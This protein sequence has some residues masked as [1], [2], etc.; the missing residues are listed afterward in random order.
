M[1]MGKPWATAWRSSVRGTPSMGVGFKQMA[2]GSEG[3][4]ELE[5]QEQEVHETV[6]MLTEDVATGW[7]QFNADD[8]GGD[9]GVEGASCGRSRPRAIRMATSWTPRRWAIRGSRRAWTWACAVWRWRRW[10]R[11]LRRGQN[12]LS[13]GLR[14]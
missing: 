9:G 3:V 8:G 14:E 12:K 5:V 7:D 10:R 13:E 11:W 2:G 6:E 4:E 1:G